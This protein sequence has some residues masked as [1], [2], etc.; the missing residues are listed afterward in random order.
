MKRRTIL[1]A[2]G[3]AVVTGSAARAQAPKL[4][5]V[6]FLSLLSEAVLRE[7]VAAFLAGLGETGF[8]G[9]RNVTIEYRWADGVVERLPALAGELVRLAPAAIVAAG[10]NFSAD[11]AKAATATIPIVFTAVS[12]PVRSGLV[13]SFSRPGGNVTGISIL[14]HELD[15]KRFDL[16]RELVPASGPIGALL[17]PKSPTAAIQRRNLETAAAAAGRT[18]VV[19]EAGSESDIAPAMT[20]F[21]ER[22]VVG[23]V[24][25]ADPFFTQQRV[26]IV[27]LAERHG[28]PGIYQWRQFAEAGGLA[29]YGPDFS[30]T[31]RQSGVYIGRILKGDK[32]GD[33]PIQQ[34]TKFQLVLNLKTA[35]ALGVTLPPS[36]LARA[37]EVID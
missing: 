23:L 32:P 2:V 33:L 27:T 8:V 29:S 19:E 25:G 9:G 3:A 6:G 15:A 5:V 22:R 10:G 37:D 36:L 35:R 20:R 11:A 12:D 26:H 21:A 7:Q 18:L 1:G 28:L 16:L 13:A 4:P 17:N 24:V 30:D 31:Y 34:P 14:S